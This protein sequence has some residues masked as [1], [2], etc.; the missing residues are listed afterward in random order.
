MTSSET[1]FAFGATPAR[2]SAPP[3]AIGFER[4]SETA[5][6][7]TGSFGTIAATH[8]ACASVWI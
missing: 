8:V 3:A 7:A 1:R 5:L 4:R 6:A 2:P